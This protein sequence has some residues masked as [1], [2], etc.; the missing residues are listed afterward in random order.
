M[1][2]LD[3]ELR[4]EHAL[5]ILNRRIAKFIRENQDK[6]FSN[7]KAKLEKYVSEEEEI[8]S[9]NQKTIDKVINEYLK[10]LKGELI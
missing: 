10:E 1:N 2:K 9:L 5:D 7:F 3:D 8:Y 6:N 4:M